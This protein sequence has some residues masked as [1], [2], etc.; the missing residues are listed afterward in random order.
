M[1]TGSIIVEGNGHGGF[2]WGYELADPACRPVLSR[3]FM[4]SHDVESGHGLVTVANH[5]WAISVALKRT[6]PYSETP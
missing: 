4:A 2:P 1:V 5:K 3:Q 6:R